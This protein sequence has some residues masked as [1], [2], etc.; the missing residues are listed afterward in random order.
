MV[1]SKV[2]YF[3]PK[4]WGTD[5]QFDEHIFQ[6]GGFNHQLEELFQY[7]KK[8]S[9]TLS[10]LDLSHRQDA[11]VANEGLGWDF[12]TKNVRILVVTGIL[13]GG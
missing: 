1:V 7:T 12:P 11:I 2:F 8:Y 5:S 4:N 10:L 9:N 6:R 13:G 3:H